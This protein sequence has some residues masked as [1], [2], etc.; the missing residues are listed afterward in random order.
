MHRNS[1]LTKFYFAIFIFCVLWVFWSERKLVKKNGTQNLKISLD[2]ALYSSR[3]PICKGND[4]PEVISAFYFEEKKKVRFLVSKEDGMRKVKSCHFEQTYWSENEYPGVSVCGPGIIGSEFYC[5]F[6]Q[7][8]Q[9]IQLI[10]AKWIISPPSKKNRPFYSF[11]EC[12]VPRERHKLIGLRKNNSVDMEGITVEDAPIISLVDWRDHLSSKK[13]RLASITF[14]E[15]RDNILLLPE[16]IEYHSMIGV[17]HF[18]I[19]FSLN[20]KS[21]RILFCTLKDYI[22]QQR[23]TLVNWNVKMDAWHKNRKQ[24][25]AL[26]H[27][28][29]YF[30]H[31][32]QY[33]TNIDADEFLY[34]V[35][36]EDTLLTLIDKHPNGFLV[37]EKMM[38]VEKDDERFSLKKG[39]VA[40]DHLE[41]KDWP[42]ACRTNLRTKNVAPTKYS[43]Y[44][45]HYVF[46]SVEEQEKGVEGKMPCLPTSLLY[47]IH[48]SD[49]YTDQRFVS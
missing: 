8:T 29:V 19:Y 46:R 49:H 14:I 44:S 3:K 38:P 28:F 48:F 31:S 33:F 18:F 25:A 11:M 9:V 7:K 32:V 43:F 27:G 42:E 4:F 12:E 17:D 20:R 41:I 15:R 5:V 36:K 22:D 10:P 45:P 13:L 35:N 16:W 23:V 1:F 39:R 37:I 47:K 6:G 21:T 34:V 30:A 40:Y 24:N 26:S 2:D